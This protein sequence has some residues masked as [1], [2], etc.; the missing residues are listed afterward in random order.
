MKLNLRVSKDT[1][2]L[3]EHIY[4]IRDEDSFVLACTDVWNRLKERRIA[5]ASSIGSL[6][7]SLEAGILVDLRGVQFEFRGA[8]A[9]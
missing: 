4:D 2:I 1:S 3:C 9:R 5:Q 8:D 7:D 6:Y